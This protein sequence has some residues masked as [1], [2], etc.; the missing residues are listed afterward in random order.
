MKPSYKFKKF[1]LVLLMSLLVF[2][3]SG[4]SGSSDNDAAIP[5]RTGIFISD[6]HFNPLSDPA[7]ADAIAQAPAS[8]WDA[9]YATSNQTTCASYLK[10]FPLSDT[11]FVLLNSAIAAMK[12]QVPDPDII[13]ISGDML[14]HYFLELVYNRIVTNPTQAGYMALVYQTEQYLAIKLTEAFPNAQILPTLGDWDSDTGVDSKPASSAFFQSF[15]SAWS[16]AVNRSGSSPD[17][18][19]TFSAGG[20]YQTKFPINTNARLIGLYTQPWAKECTNGC[21]TLG[22]AELQWFTQQLHDAKE[23]GQKVWLL[24]H[25]PPGIDANTTASNM[26]KGQS[27][28]EAVTPFWAD[29]YS[30]QLYALFAQYKGTIDFGVF[31]HEHYDDFRIVNDSSGN[32]IFGVKLPP[33]ITPLHNNPAFIAFNYNPDLG[34]IIDEST[35]YL[36]NLASNPT[37]DAAVWE[38]EYSFNNTYGQDAFDSNGLL[39]AVARI[40]VQPSAQQSYVNYYPVLYPAGNI[41]PGGLSPFLGWSC[42][43]NKLT[44]ADY[45][46]CSC[47]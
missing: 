26:A 10:E 20:Y 46:S 18:M 47:Q 43:F 34:V 31:A 4:C 11:N 7:I 36:S 42:A 25:I 12:A 40:I 1:S 15:A 38:I 23:Q 22:N 8:Q 27:C 29:A 5:S 9:I 14:V 13:I 17:F 45:T 3:T 2:S 21:S 28:Q 35:F 39:N 33:S 32:F 19:D 16:S 30:S 6:I 41:L 37:A 44:V 24:G